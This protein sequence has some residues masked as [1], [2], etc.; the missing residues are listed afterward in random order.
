MDLASEHFSHQLVELF[1]PDLPP[2]LPALRLHSRS[3]TVRGSIPPMAGILHQ[4][5]NIWN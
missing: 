3:P 4:I 2:R 5:N 1:T